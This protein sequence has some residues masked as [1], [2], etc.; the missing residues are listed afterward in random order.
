MVEYLDAMD[1][2]VYTGPEPEN[3]PPLVL[4]ALGPRMLE[5]AA[6]RTRGAH[7]YFVPLEHTALAREVMGPDALLAPELAFVLSKDADEARAI[8]RDFA[9]LYLAHPN[10]TNNLLRLGW[11]EED[12]AHGGSDALMDAIIPWGSRTVIRDRVAAHLAAGAD[13]VAVQVLNGRGNEFPIA[14]WREIA[15]ALSDFYPANGPTTQRHDGPN[16][17]TFRAAR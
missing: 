16:R 5:L 9:E 2:A 13:H 6:A 3:D 7:P 10:Y 8:A 11:S 17:R 12:M 15:P 4:A 1:A 14:E